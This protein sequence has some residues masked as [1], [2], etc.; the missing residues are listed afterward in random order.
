MAGRGSD[1]IRGRSPAGARSSPGR[2]VVFGLA[3]G[4][5]VAGLVLLLLQVAPPRP[6]PPAQPGRL[7]A[8]DLTLDLQNAGWITHDDVGGPTPAAVQ[9]GFQMP[10]SMMPGLPEHGTHRL[11]LEA[12]LT[13]LGSVAATFAPQEFSVREAGGA[14]WSLKQPATFGSGS[15]QPGQSRSLDLF[16]DVPET[17]AKLDLV[18]SHGG[19][20][21]S[22]SVD[23]PPPAAHTHGEG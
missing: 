18:W 12:V 1:V 15:L 16:F 8:G 21:R 9:N 6:E 3:A 4:A 7:V 14:T 2:L 22:L 17:V 20:D 23:S 5:A 11:Y 19:Q 13:D 10:A